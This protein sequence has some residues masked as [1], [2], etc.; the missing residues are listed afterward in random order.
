M[1]E[2]KG[3]ILLYQTVDGESRI[4]VTLCNNT[5]WLTLDQ[6]AELFQRNKS[7]ISRHIKNVFESGELQENSVV[8][9]FATT[10]SDGK[11][12]QV[13]YYN[14]DMIISIGYRVKS[15]RGVQFRIWATQILKEYLVKGLEHERILV[16]MST[17]STKAAIF[18]IIHSKGK[19]ERKTLKKYGPPKRLQ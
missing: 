1:E 7:T 19:C 15:Y 18:E 13:A 14:L 12:Y 10:A 3:Q 8:A 17:S 5:V 4:E 2:N 11:I 16:F 9:F 6:M